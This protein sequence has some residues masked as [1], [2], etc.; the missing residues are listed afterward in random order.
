MKA[1]LVC[2]LLVNLTYAKDL[3]F[4]VVPQQSPLVLMKKWTPIIDKISHESGLNII[5]KIETSIPKFEE[6]LY[7]GKYDIA[8]VNPY[9]YVI[10]HKKQNYTP[11]LRANK[12]IQGIIVASKEIVAIEPKK[13]KGKT[14]LFP[15]PNAFAA[16][17]LTKYELKEKYNFNIDK[18][19][20]VMYVNSHDSVFKGVARELGEYGGAIVRT[21]NNF[22]DKES[23]DKLN[24]IYKTSKYPSHPIIVSNQL[25]QDIV[26]KLKKGFASLDKNDL[27]TL[28][29]KKLIP[30]DDKNYDI[31]K[32]LAIELGIY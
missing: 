12:L 11:I 6:E 25:S 16:T 32:K 26:S 4:G 27:K 21:Y 3:V 22:K 20:K 29:M 24:I 10:A 18:D 8:Y 1:I 5:L 13:L 17:L 9:H 7:S 31:I 23:K 28:S 30:I 19:A 2:L 14:F 15:A